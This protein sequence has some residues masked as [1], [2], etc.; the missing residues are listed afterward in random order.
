MDDLHLQSIS[1]TELSN[2]SSWFDNHDAA[3]MLFK[4]SSVE[5]KAASDAVAWTASKG[6]DVVAVAYFSQSGSDASIYLAVD[7]SMRRHG[8]GTKVLE[9]VLGHPIFDKALRIKADIEMSNVGAQKLVAK[10]GF[11]K[12]GQT[13]DGMMVFERRT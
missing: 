10:S 13:E 6:D 1:A 4:Q 8:Y 5:S 12:T 11:V 9:L 3:D 2:Y 7:P